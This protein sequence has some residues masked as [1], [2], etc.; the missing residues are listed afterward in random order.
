M[1]SEG[2][3]MI[4]SL[5]RFLKELKELT[6]GAK[7]SGLIIGILGFIVD[8]LLWQNGIHT[9]YY[10]KSIYI[11]I[12]I[13]GFILF[14]NDICICVKNNNKQKQ[15]EKELIDTLKHLTGI[16][17]NIIY[18]FAE[19]GCLSVEIHTDEEINAAWC[20]RHLLNGLVGIENDRAIINHKTL[21]ILEK[22]FF[23]F[24][25]N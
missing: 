12:G 16:E 18:K 2:I 17:H 6:T 24:R 5:T 23:P 10:I 3:N 22:A 4:E 25:K 9:P 20:L 7:V 13:A 15:K 21:K 14:V 19:Y 1:H 11:I 8:L